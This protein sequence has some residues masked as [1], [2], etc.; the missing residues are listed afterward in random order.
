MPRKQTP[1]GAVIERLCE[2][3]DLTSASSLARKAMADY[4][5]LFKDF[6]AARDLIRMYRGS[7]GE[8]SRK[9]LKVNKG[10]IGTGENPLGI[11][12]PLDSDIKPVRLDHVKYNRTGVISD[13]HIPN[14][15]PGPLTLA[16]RRF[17]EQGM[18]R[19]IINGDWLDN[20]PFSRHDGK[21]AGPKD[22]R[23]IFEMAERELERLRDLFPDAEI[24]WAEG[25][26]DYWYMRWLM[27][28]APM[29][30][31]D[32]YFHLEERL[33]LADYNIRFI[34]QTRYLQLGKLN[35]CHG[36]QI[37]RNGGGVYPARTV[38]NAVKKSML[39]GH[40]HRES[41]YT[42]TSLGDELV[43]CWTT[44]CL[45]T[46]TPTYQTFGGKANYGFAEVYTERNGDF[47]V[48]NSRITRGKIV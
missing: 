47:H 35:V 26:H 20:T 21:P 36:H 34:D 19:I 30:F 18:N 32:Q 48:V 4:P 33:H 46:L 28:H 17:L 43:T 9:K 39:I 23:N 15:R 2:R 5:L 25:N 3:F 22:A 42:E 6:G 12:A 8:M 38:Y 14:H 16:Y 24:I 40:V 41:S 11:L 45:C 31:D 44:G 27:K 1:H 10:T 37:T 7:M 13:V 29:I